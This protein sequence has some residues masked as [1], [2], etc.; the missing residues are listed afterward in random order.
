[1]IRL[2]LTLEEARLAVADKLTEIV[3]SEAITPPDPNQGA[4]FTD[5][6]RARSLEAWDGTL[7]PPAVL[8]CTGRREAKYASGWESIGACL[9][10]AYHKEPCKFSK[11]GE[12]EKVD[13]TAVVPLGR[14]P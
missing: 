8:R 6:E 10:L 4:C 5:E 9:L 13:L 7:P 2:V 14:Q 1:V 3:I 11:D 12:A